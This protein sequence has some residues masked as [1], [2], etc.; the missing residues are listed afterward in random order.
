MIDRVISFRRG[1][2]AP[3]SDWLWRWRYGRVEHS[4]NPAGCAA[5]PQRTQVI[6]YSR[7]DRSP[8][9]I[10][11]QVTYPIVTAMLGAPKVKAVRGI[12]DFGS[13]LVYVILEDGTDLYLAR[14]RTQEYLSGVLSTLPAG[15]R[16][17]LGPDATGL[18]WVFQYAL[19]DDSGKQS[20]SQLR[21]TQD[22]FLRYHLH[23]VPGVAEVASVGGMVP[24]YQVTVDAAR[25]RAMGIPFAAVVE[26]VRRSNVETGGR[27][28]EFG[29]A[30]YMIRGRG[31]LTDTRELE[32]AV[33]AGGGSSQIVRVKDVGKVAMGPEMRRGVANLDG[34]GET[35]SGIVIMRQGSNVV[36]VI[37]RVKRKIREI[38]PGLP[39]G[40]R[41]VPVY[42]RSELVH[43]VIDNLRWTLT[44]I[45]LTVVAVIL[46]FLWHPPSAVVPSVTMSLTILAVA[47]P[48]HL[49]GLSFNVMSLG[50]I[51]IATGALVDAAIVVAEQT[52][53]K[54]GEWQKDGGQGDVDNVILSAVKEVGRPAFFAL[55]IMAM[56]FLP[57]LTLDGQEAG[58]SIRWPTP[59]V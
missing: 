13:S 49:M 30:E 32:E 6:L 31:Y 17:E 14:S 55:A 39:A 26:A 46:P 37:D 27:F 11:D 47:V 36:D 42:D 40:V 12:S 48:F 53:K 28:L 5:G 18:G 2:A 19:T 33:V 41:V 52:H 44:E 24:Q 34:R 21:T 10:E 58:C 25:L 22:F 23:S 1:G 43:R 54:L 29:G 57:L 15:V 7:W 50:G 35:V 9:L 38:S 51:A 56:A 4:P 20:P 45:I 16:T 59:R 8:D 3:S